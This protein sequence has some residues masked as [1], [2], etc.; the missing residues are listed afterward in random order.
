M[1]AVEAYGMPSAKAGMG[2][3][4]VNYPIIIDCNV[5]S[6]QVWYWL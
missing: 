5:L 3:G 4:A 2:S 6:A 1:W